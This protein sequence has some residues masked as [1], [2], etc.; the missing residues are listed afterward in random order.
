MYDDKKQLVADLFWEYADRCGV[1]QV[2]PTDS[3]ISPDIHW[4]AD[5]DEDDWDKLFDEDNED[6]D[7]DEDEDDRS[8]TGRLWFKHRIKEMASVVA[9]RFRDR[10]ATLRVEVRP[11]NGDEYEPD[12]YHVYLIASLSKQRGTIE[13][14]PSLP[15]ATK[16]RRGDAMLHRHPWFDD[17]E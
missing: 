2:D 7:E 10:L 12:C 13:R 16:D 3:P 1:E 15:A 4:E 6:E 14:T 17:G 9:R 11:V 5:L 8:N